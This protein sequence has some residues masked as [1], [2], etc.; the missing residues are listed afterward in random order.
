MSDFF[1]A[2]LQVA[3]FCFGLL[4]F[5]M[6]YS[7]K[8]NTLLQSLK[9]RNFINT[10]IFKLFFLALIIAAFLPGVSV[11]LVKTRDQISLYINRIK[12]AAREDGAV[13]R[14]EHKQHIIMLELDGA[15]PDVLY[16]LDLPT[17][18]PLWEKGF[19]YYYAWT[20]LPTSSGACHTSAVTGVTP[21]NHG[22]MKNQFPSH[23]KA[24]TIFQI[25]ENQGIKTLV[26]EEL[27]PQ[28]YGGMFL[29][30]GVSHPLR[31]F[32]LDE[33]YS[34]YK[35]RFSHGDLV[36]KKG[37]DLILDF[38]KN[39]EEL[40][41]IISLVLL[42]TDCTGHAF[43]PESEEYKKAFFRSDK[44][45]KL[46]LDAVKRFDPGLR[47]TTLI[48][49]SDHGMPHG[50]ASEQERRMSLFL[51]GKNIR[52]GTSLRPVSIIDIAPTVA[53]LLDI[54]AEFEGNPLSEALAK[55]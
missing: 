36:N 54:D 46:L 29:L 31:A 22:I 13:K 11:V 19:K 35:W 53:R 30:K 7:K 52:K 8:F 40:P 41:G 14:M 26:L 33:P 55:N 10:R 45:V 27:S 38:L 39:A 21:K 28:Y 18:K 23:P 25:A 34:D 32:F 5:L 9:S 20:V 1:I 43:G 12:L 6:L 50:G 51:S 49:Y 48:V 4:L 44:D 24:P 3:I 17:L 16:S 37:M 2:Q 47:N 15:R 42:D